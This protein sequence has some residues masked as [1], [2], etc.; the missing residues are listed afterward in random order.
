MFSLTYALKTKDSHKSISIPPEDK[1]AII[2]QRIQKHEIQA[3]ISLMQRL[4][5]NRPIIKR[6]S[7]GGRNIQK[8]IKKLEQDRHEVRKRLRRAIKQGFKSSISAGT[9]ATDTI[10]IDLDEYRAELMDIEDDDDEPDKAKMK[11]HWSETVI[12]IYY[13]LFMYLLSYLLKK[14]NIFILCH[15]SVTWIIL[16]MHLLCLLRIWHIYCSLGKGNTVMSNWCIYM[17]NILLNTLDVWYLYRWLILVKL[18]FNSIGNFTCVVQSF[19]NHSIN[20]WSIS[21]WWLIKQKK[22]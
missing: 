16:D 22:C 9:D 5:N 21:D 17:Y 12:V 8:R 7:D 2:Q 13:L 19:D 18:L 11:E 1:T 15:M 10:V 20:D 4:Y 14:M 3:S 6:L